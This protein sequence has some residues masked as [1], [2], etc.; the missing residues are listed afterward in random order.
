MAQ[1]PASAQVAREPRLHMR[2]LEPHGH[3]GSTFGDDPFGRFAERFARSFG[4]PRFLIVQTGIVLVWLALNAADI[5]HFDPY[6][7]I[8]LNLAFSTQAA[9]AAPMILLA[10]TRQS[11]RDRTWTE[12]DAK[13]R[14]EISAAILA[15]LRQNTD[16]TQQVHD[17]AERI[18]ALTREV[19]GRVVVRP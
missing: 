4:T 9:Y 8:L 14:E 19:H 6:P 10:Q 17:L 16:L 3:L 18:E 7:F 5:A 13:H 12:A 1:L 15:L 2:F 11:E